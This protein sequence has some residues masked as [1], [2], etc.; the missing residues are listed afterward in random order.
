MRVH[1]NAAAGIFNEWNEY[2]YRSPGEYDH[3]NI[4]QQQIFDAFSSIK[5]KIDNFHVRFTRMNSQALDIELRSLVSFH[6]IFFFIRIDTP[7]V[8][9][10]DGSA[11]RVDSL[12]L[13]LFQP[14]KFELLIVWIRMNSYALMGFIAFKGFSLKFHSDFRYFTSILLRAAGNQ[15][16]QFNS[17]YSPCLPAPFKWTILI[18]ISFVGKG[19]CTEA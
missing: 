18:E 6:A 15:T 3:G 8:Q 17:I 4:Y 13:F 12:E 14:S 1:E 2:P 11:Y 19:G 7:F 9:T 16:I 5:R 10:F